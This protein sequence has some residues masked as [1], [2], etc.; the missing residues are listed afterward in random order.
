MKSILTVHSVDALL[1]SVDKIGEFAATHHSHLT[2]LVLGLVHP[3]P[4]I[5]YPEASGY[6]WGTMHDEKLKLA[7]TRAAELN[8]RLIKQGVLVS[9]IIAC[10]EMSRVA[11]LVSKNALYV[12]YLVLPRSDALNGKIYDH[13]LDGGIFLAGA[14][15][16]TVPEEIAEAPKLKTVVAAWHPSAH[17]A[18]ALRSVLPLLDKNA[19]LHIVVVDPKEHV[20]GPNPGDDIAAYLAR[21]DISVTVDR[22]AANDKPVSDV[23]HER[24]VDLDADL[25]VVGA[26]GHSKMREWLLG[27]TT[28]NMLKNFS[29]PLWLCH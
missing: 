9:T 1:H 7:Q 24:S 21:K 3:Q 5:T 26:H 28:N 15:V 22:V 16:L 10:R 20:Y 11:H 2:V 25:I 27:S 12:D 19:E 6:D 8:E 23:L 4:T 17:T 29:T 14:P 18:R 13:C